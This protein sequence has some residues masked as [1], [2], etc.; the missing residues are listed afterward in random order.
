[1]ST[2]STNLQQLVEQMWDAAKGVLQQDAP[3]L[4]DTAKAE[5]AKL[6]QTTVFIETN[7]LSGALSQ[8]NAHAMLD[9]QKNT[10][11]MILWTIEEITLTMVQDAINA[12]LAKIKDFIN[13]A[14][15]FTL[16]A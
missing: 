16:I 11:K 12:A 2:I 7:V 9:A 8:D 15:R 3:V 10:A 14:V 1:M 13:D 5:F 6:L 4:R